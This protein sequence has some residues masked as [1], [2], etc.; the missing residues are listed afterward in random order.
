M[1]AALR[2]ADSAVNN[3]NKTDA[4]NKQ[5]PKQQIMEM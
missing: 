5:K 3:K 4:I 1:G 2:K